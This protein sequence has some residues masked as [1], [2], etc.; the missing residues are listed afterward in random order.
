MDHFPIELKSKE[1]IPL[2][3]KSKE[4]Q[5][6]VSFDFKINWKMIQMSFIF[7]LLGDPNLLRKKS[8]K[9]KIRK[10]WSYKNESIK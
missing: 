4:T 6:C 5:V 1:T 2:I 9:Q 7:I 10:R 8:V 3:L